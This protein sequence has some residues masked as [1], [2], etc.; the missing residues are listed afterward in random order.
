MAFSRL[1]S[2]PLFFITL[3]VLLSIPFQGNGLSPKKVGSTP[4]HLSE[5]IEIRSYTVTINGTSSIAQVSDNYVCATLDYDFCNQALGPCFGVRTNVLDLDLTNDILINAVTAL[6]PLLRLGGSKA[7]ELIYDINNNINPCPSGSL[8]LTM[9]RW[10]QLNA[11]VQQT[12][13]RM[14]FGLNAMTGRMQNHSDPWNSTNCEEFLEYTVNQG[15]NITGW[16]FG[17]EKV[18]NVNSANFSPSTYA[19]DVQELRSILDEVYCDHHDLQ[20]PLLIAPDAK[21]NATWFQEFIQLSGS[22]VVDRLSH[23]IYNLG[24]GDMVTPVHVEKE[25]FDGDYLNKEISV[26]QSL[27]DITNTYGPWAKPMVGESG[28]LSQGGGPGI[29]N[30]FVNSFW[31]LDQLAMAA[32]FDTDIYCRQA[33]VTGYYSLLD[34]TTFQPNPDYYAALLWKQVMGRTVLSV[35]KPNETDTSLRVYAH[36][37]KQQTNS[38]TLLL[39]N[40]SNNTQYFVDTTASIAS[41]ARTMAKF[42]KQSNN[43]KFD[44]AQPRYEYHLTSPNDDPLSRTILL[45]GTPLELQ[46]DNQI[47]TLLPIISNCSQPI[48]VLPVSI[49]FVTLPNVRAPACTVS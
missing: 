42:R 17:N 12:N 34:N 43:L 9:H 18:D 47:P 22:G 33:L 19:Q 14:V 16:E 20:K 10:D 7:D 8:C 39:I 38:I 27:Q 49:V 40:L 21:F 26:F 23:H 31:Y 35:A 36:C 44:S 24:K 5:I 28:G 46:A 41:P 48:S 6:S 25:V 4:R 37:S 11:F 32:T 13:A 45:N 15:Y 3:L 30:T 29:S 2:E 1:C